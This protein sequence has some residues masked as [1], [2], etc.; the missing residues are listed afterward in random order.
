MTIKSGTFEAGSVPMLR[1]LDENTLVF[2]GTRH[3]DSAMRTAQGGEPVLLVVHGRYD[4]T[5]AMA[6]RMCA[7]TGLRVSWGDLISFHEIRRDDAGAI[8]AERA[9]SLDWDAPIVVAGVPGLYD[10]IMGLYTVDD[11]PAP[12]SAEYEKMDSILRGL[13]SVRR[14]HPH[15][16]Y[17]VA[18]R[19]GI[20]SPQD[21][22]DAGEFME[23][24]LHEMRLRGMN[25]PDSVE[26]ID[27]DIAVKMEERF[28]AADGFAA[29][30]AAIDAVISDDPC[31]AHWTAH[32]ALESV[33]ARLA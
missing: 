6:R 13:Y 30:H 18:E 3:Y 29:W 21:C 9:E 7:D 8:A 20:H 11:H 2:P 32:E 15:I 26:D 31:T 25:I 5:E 33:A 1:Q 24:V 17:A 4:A 14:R 28:S 12:V 23:R 22:A 27:A 19:E 16:L 10:R